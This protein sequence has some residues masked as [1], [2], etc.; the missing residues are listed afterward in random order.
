MNNKY[1]PLSGQLR[2]LLCV[3]SEQSSEGKKRK[4]TQFTLQQ[5][6]KLGAAFAR[7]H[8]PTAAECLALSAETKLDKT[9]VMLLSEVSAQ[10][11]RSLQEVA[12]SAQPAV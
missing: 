11:T 5:K 10:L 2:L 9:Q 8:H 6:E 4:R 12:P 1:G 3:S 7:T